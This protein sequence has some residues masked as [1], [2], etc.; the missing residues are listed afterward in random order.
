[1]G[2]TVATAANLQPRE[3]LWVTLAGLAAD[4]DGAGVIAEILTRHT[5]HPLLWWTQYH[6]VVGH[7][8][9]FGVAFAVLAA[10]LA[11]RRG[12]VFGLA[13]L[14]YHLHLIA[15]VLGGRGPTGDLWT[16]PYFWPF[17]D[18][19]IWSWQNQWKLNSWQNLLITAVLM[20][21]AFRL[22][23]K[24]GYSPVSLISQRADAAVVEVLRRRFP[25]P[26]TAPSQPQTGNGAQKAGE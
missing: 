20:F 23:W 7:N 22:A 26:K 16:I 5:A 6:H 2:W 9:L 25:L 8:L 17:S 4:V 24:R 10:A 18:A 3:R 13:L 14:S 1:M 11:Q 19:W 21:W 15:D 12:L